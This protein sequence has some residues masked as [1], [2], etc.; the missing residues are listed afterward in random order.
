MKK[1]ISPV[2]TVEIVCAEGLVAASINIDPTA[3]T[4]NGGDANRRSFSDD[5]LWDG[6]EN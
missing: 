4:P 2:A 3:S 1:Y 6:D 5:D